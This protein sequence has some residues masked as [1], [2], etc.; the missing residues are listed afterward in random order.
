MWQNPQKGLVWDMQPNPT[1]GLLESK[2]KF[3]ASVHWIVVMQ[4]NAVAADLEVCLIKMNWANSL[5]FVFRIVAFFTTK[6]IS[7]D[8]SGILI[9]RASAH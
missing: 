8:F 4:C 6:L 5:G 1:P 2:S 3:N 9:R 7:I